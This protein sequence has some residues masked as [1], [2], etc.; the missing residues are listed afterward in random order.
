MAEE[1]NTRFQDS[2]IVDSPCTYIPDEIFNALTAVSIAD[3]ASNDLSALQNT[4][5][6]E[7]RRQ[8][9]LPAPPIEVVPSSFQVCA[10]SEAYSYSQAE[11][12]IVKIPG[13]V[14][15]DQS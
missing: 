5:S 11:E 9:A 15:C 10:Y 12:A 14:S 8:N 4:L 6:G 7:T 2:M 3:T 1:S 13:R